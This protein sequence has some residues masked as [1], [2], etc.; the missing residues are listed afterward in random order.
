[1]LTPSI[2]PRTKRLC[3]WCP[4]EADP[5]VTV[6]THGV[7]SYICPHVIVVFYVDSATGECE[8]VWRRT[9]IYTGKRETEH[10]EE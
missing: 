2:Q 8:E 4:T 5:S 10:M 3:P 7:F 1:M 6:T 9:R